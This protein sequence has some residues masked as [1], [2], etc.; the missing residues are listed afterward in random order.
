MSTKRCNVALFCDTAKNISYIKYLHLDM[1]YE[2]EPDRG[3]LIHNSKP[4]VSLVSF[5]R[6]VP[7]D[8][9]K[10]SSAHN[11][12]D[13]YVWMLIQPRHVLILSVPLNESLPTACLK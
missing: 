6:A 1:I 8:V 3:T 7:T 4:R 12:R 13:T 11:W 2:K 5:W 9:D 10:S